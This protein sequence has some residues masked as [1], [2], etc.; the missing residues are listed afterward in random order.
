MEPIT[1]ENGQ[2]AAVPEKFIN[3]ETGDVNIDALVKSYKA[4][5][6]RLSNAIPADNPERIKKALG[7]PETPEEY[8]VKVD[9]G[10]LEP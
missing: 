6:Q 2:Q 7:V 8:D 5:E 10:L 1:Q 4:L 9:N 3:A